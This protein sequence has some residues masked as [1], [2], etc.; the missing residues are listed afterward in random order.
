MYF[1]QNEQD[2][3]KAPALDQDVTAATEATPAT[4]PAPASSSLTQP[5]A[6]TAAPSL[7]S[8]KTPVSRPALPL[9]S[10]IPAGIKYAKKSDDPVT[11][12]LK[13]AT[14]LVLQ[15]KFDAA[16][17]KV[18]AALVAAPQSPAAYC[19]RG[20]I[21]AEQKLWDQAA[22]DYQMVLELDPKNTQVKFD[23][24][25]TLFMQKKY[26]EARPGFAGLEQ[27]PD[28][29]DLATYKVF[30]CDLLGAH[31][32]VAGKELDA[33]NQSGT[34]ASYYFANGAWFL[35]HQK[36]EDARGW[37]TSA[38]KIYS[39]NK[40]NIYSTSLID[41]GYLPLPPPTQK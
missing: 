5:R 30:L 11:L 20:N 9:L 29:G 2:M 1:Y 33:F 3:D 23:M 16:L 28:L 32:D 31:E 25:E 37:L 15:K 21:Y 34:D 41:L 18:N 19:L 35:Y 13:E 8:L 7:L 27:D 36:T 12:L 10:P 26:D 39:P 14:K 22:K 4:N 6:N 17:E 38:A 40:F 24:A